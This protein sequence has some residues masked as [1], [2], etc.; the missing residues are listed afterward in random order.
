MQTQIIPSEKLHRDTVKK[1]KKLPAYLP[2]PPFLM[3]VQGSAG[4]G[5][6]SFTWSLVNEYQKK[7]YFDLILIWNRCSDSNHAWKKLETSKTN[8]DL[9]SHYDDEEFRTIIEGIDEIQG[10]RREQKKAPYNILMILD[11][12]VMSNITGRGSGRPT[13]LDEMIINRR[14]HNV[15]IL[16]TSQNYKSLSPNARTNNLSML[17]LLRAGDRD[18]KLIHEEHNSGEAS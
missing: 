16:I 1:N 10:T 8:L 6:S 7:K 2:T 18:K 13:A 17:V 12:M 9:F 15:S 14:H 4:S 11:D 5:K 3:V